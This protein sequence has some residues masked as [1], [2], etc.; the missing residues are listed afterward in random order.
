VQEIFYAA[1]IEQ[2]VFF[3]AIDTAL[4]AWLR[5]KCCSAEIARGLRWEM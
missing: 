3:L 5:N 1:Q 4:I 2:K